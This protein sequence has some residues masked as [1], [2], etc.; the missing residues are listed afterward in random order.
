ME[1]IFEASMRWMRYAAVP[2]GGSASVLG[3]KCYLQNCALV[4]LNAQAELLDSSKRYLPLT[5][6]LQTYFAT[7][8]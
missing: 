2:Q 5:A 4:R 3:P 7:V 8:P 1:G 6:Q